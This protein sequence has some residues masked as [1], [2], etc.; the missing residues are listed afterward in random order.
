M[1]DEA[2]CFD[3]VRFLLIRHGKTQGNLER[4]YI[5][6]MGEIDFG[7]FKGKNADDLLG[8]E[9]YEAWLETGCMGDIPGG[10]SVS[11]FKERCFDAFGHIA[12][13]SGSGAMA[14]PMAMPMATTMAMLTPHSALDGKSY[15]RA[16]QAIASDGIRRRSSCDNR[17]VDLLRRLFCPAVSM[18]SLFPACGVRAGE[19]SVLAA[20]G[21]QAVEG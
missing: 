7:L 1:V 20:A 13:K 12:D 9:D 19:F 3:M 16:G 14:T 15:R 4:R 6:P 21:G 11:L 17:D 5:C 2:S 10:D 18:L 8:D